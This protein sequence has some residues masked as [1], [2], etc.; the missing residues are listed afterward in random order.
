MNLFRRLRDLC[1]YG[2]YWKMGTKDGSVVLTMD[3]L[4]G[5][6]TID[7]NGVGR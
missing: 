5:R 3:R 1:V 6:S 4:T 7:F 2:R